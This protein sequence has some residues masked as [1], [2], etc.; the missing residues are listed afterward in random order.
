MPYGRGYR[1]KTGMRK[2]RSTI[3]KSPFK[4]VNTRAMVARAKTRSL[5][6]LIKGVTLKQA[7][8]CYRSKSVSI[9]N[10]FHDVLKPIDIWGPTNVGIWPNQG[11]G[12]GERR[13]DEI[14]LTGIMYRG[15]F[16]VPHDRRNV[17]FKMW[18]VPFNTEQGDPA[19]YSNFFHNIT[20]D[21]MI[22]PVQTDRWR[23][24]RYLG[25]FRCRSV[26]QA[27]GDPND[28]TIHVKR[29]IPMKRKVRFIQDSSQQPS[30]M[31]EVGRIMV[32]AYDTITTLITDIVI[33]RSENCFT[34]Y[35]K[36]P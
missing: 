32:L 33:T 28:K 31:P 26:D 27:T 16:Q 29:W 25:K 23:G 19:T 2:R 12:D 4:R 5:V 10:Y 35:Y 7:E 3:K 6:K 18:Y 8:T 21:G 11:A 36:D 24:L 30:N 22:D 1:R 14:Y 15:V 17:A 13:G 20:G 34:I 9:P